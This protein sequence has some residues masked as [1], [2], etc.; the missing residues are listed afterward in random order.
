M[1]PLLPFAAG[2]LTGAVVVK[3]WR[4]DK[5]SLQLDTARDKIREATVSGLSRLESSSARMRDRLSAVEATAP[6][7]TEAPLAPATPAKA[8]TKARARK[9]APA[10]DSTPKRRRRTKAIAPASAPEAGE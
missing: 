6:A 7:A 10:A 9:P 2:L 8:S 1:L 3:L 5:T 4:K